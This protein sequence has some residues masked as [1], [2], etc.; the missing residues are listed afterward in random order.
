MDDLAKNVLEDVAAKGVSFIDLQ[1]TDVLGTTKSVTIPAEHL[2][3][4]FERGIWFDGSSIQG[5]ARIHE[6]DMFL[7]PDAIT[8]RVL[9]WTGGDV[10]LRARVI[11]DIMKPDGEHFE[12][13]PRYVLTV[14][15]VG[16]KFTLK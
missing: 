11:C 12:G 7:A 6:A 5:F 10:P 8:Y 13:D 14:Y 15:G 9:P 3:E 4:A 16:Y 2:E 1:F